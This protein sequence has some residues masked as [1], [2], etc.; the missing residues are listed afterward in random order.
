M[1]ARIEIPLE[2]YNGMK[3]EIEKLE[4]KLVEVKNELEISN[5]KLLGKEVTYEELSEISLF[6]RIF[7]WGKILK[8]FFNHQ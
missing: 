3:G 2:E 6:D 7:N 5:N 4:K 1:G 8:H